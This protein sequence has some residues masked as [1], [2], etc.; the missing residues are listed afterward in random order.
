MVLILSA[1]WLVMASVDSAEQVLPHVSTAEIELSLS[2][3]P[4]LLETAVLTI[5]VKTEVELPNGGV[6]VVLPGGIMK[7]GGALT[8]TTNLRAGDST[9]FSCNINVLQKGT[10]SIDAY[11]RS[12]AGEILDSASLKLKVSASGSVLLSEE[13]ETRVPLD[14]LLP[15]LEAATTGSFVGGAM[16]ALL[17]GIVGA[18]IGAAFEVGLI[19]GSPGLVSV[20]SYIGGSLGS[21]L[22]SAYELH[23]EVP[24]KEQ[25][26]W[27]ALAGA[28][29]AAVAPTTIGVYTGHLIPY[30][31]VTVPIGAVAGYELG[32]RQKHDSAT[33]W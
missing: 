7:T 4:S 24:G 14:V 21:A 15:E 23:R 5:T 9:S 10:W 25:D 30:F 3:V 16:C 2:K 11:L 22:G 33:P 19:E 27:W 17:G 32:K 28:G 1:A 31:L 20:G 18:G 12:G 26:I 13:T 6:Q 29:V 8:W